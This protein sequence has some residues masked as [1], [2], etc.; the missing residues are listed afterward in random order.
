MNLVVE[1]FDAAKAYYGLKNAGNGGF[2]CGHAVINK[3][4]ASSLKQGVR[5]NN[6]SAFAL[7]DLDKVDG[8]K[9]PFLVGFYTM[10][11]GEIVSDS[12]KAKGATGL[13]PRVA[14]LKLLMLGVDLEYQGRKQKGLQC[15]SRLMKHA[16]GRA[17]VAC[18]DLG[19]RGMYLDADPGALNFYLGLGFDPLEP[20][21][22]SKPTPMFLFREMIPAGI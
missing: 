12:L 4:V 2:D 20:A 14:C 13:T 8:G 21:D 1:A 11:M 6:Y 19:G 22:P 18:E 7:V 16:L 15:G 5:A 3:F 10:A 17:R 9:N